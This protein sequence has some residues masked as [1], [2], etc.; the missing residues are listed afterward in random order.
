[1][2]KKEIK[3]QIAYDE[4]RLKE[5]Q[6]GYKDI[7]EYQELQAE[8]DELNEKKAKLEKRQT[9]IRLQYRED[10]V[11]DLEF[12]REELKYS[13]ELL[14]K[15]ERGLDPK[16]FNDELIAM[17]KAFYQGTTYHQF[18]KLQWV[19]DDGEY[20]LFKVNCHSAYIGRFSGSVSS[21]ATWALFKIEADFNG[22]SMSSGINERNP[23]CIWSKEGGRWGEKRDMKLV[24]EAIDN[25]EN[26]K[27]MKSFMESIGFKFVNNRNDRAWINEDIVIKYTT[28]RTH[29][30]GP[31]R[32]KTEIN[33]HE[34][35]CKL[36]IGSDYYV[37]M[38]KNFD[39]LKKKYP[40]F[41]EEWEKHK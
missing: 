10:S 38:P 40:N 4:E 22:N 12:A 37:N 29:Q 20:A 13:R 1:M 26:N 31:K 27:F 5:V 36:Y 21:G 2:T 34:K 7:K 32:G 39:E 23:L 24:E 14:R 8:I 19:S 17:F 33:H 6:E 18:T 35:V 25:Y 30:I 3:E 16:D 41:V 9:E 28:E 15:A 11:D